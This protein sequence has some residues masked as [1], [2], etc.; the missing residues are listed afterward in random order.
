MSLHTIE[1]LTSSILDFQANMVRVTYRK[2][3]TLVD[4]E[5]E[6]T[7]AEALQSI[8]GS[9]G[10]AVGEDETGFIIQWQNLGFESE[11]II[12]EFSEVGVLGL[13]CLVSLPLYFSPV[14]PSSY[15]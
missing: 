15:A 12:A 1:D 8:W 11:D 3:T 4:P 5:N 9:S 7:H 6:P 2:K 10:L 14:L 13:D